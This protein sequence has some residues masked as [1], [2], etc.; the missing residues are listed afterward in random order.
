MIT[1]SVVTKFEFRPITPEGREKFGKLLAGTEW[2]LIFCQ[3]A[4]ETADKL[5]ELLQR[6]IAES[7]P[8]KTKSFRNTDTPWFNRRIKK[9]VMR[10]LRI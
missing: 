4:S 6:Y 5:D 7:F 8:L 10:K 3:S 9:L 2:E 1:K